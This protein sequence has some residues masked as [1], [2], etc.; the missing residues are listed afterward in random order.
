MKLAQKKAIIEALKEGGRYLVSALLVAIVP[1]ILTGI[2]TQT[3][4]IGIN[5]VLV[6]AI[7]LYTF[8]T[9]VLRM[10]D[11]GFHTYNKERTALET[12][13]ASMGIIPF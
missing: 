7:G 2:N 10:A 4:A 3:G 13:G 6:K 8:F 9:I 12:K 5:W 1:I 11:K